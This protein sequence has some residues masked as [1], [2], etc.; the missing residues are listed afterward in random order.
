VAKQITNGAQPLGAVLASKEIYDTFMAQGGPEY[1]LEFA[2][3]YTYSAH[4]VACAVGL[5]TINILERENMLVA[6]RLQ[7][8]QRHPQ[9][10]PRR[11]PDH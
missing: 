10:W 3:G 8:H 6:Q 7:A 5:A 11:W 1:L 9:L 4:P 2:H